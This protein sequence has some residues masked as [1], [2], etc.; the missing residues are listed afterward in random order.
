[1]LCSVGHFI[2]GITLVSSLYKQFQLLYRNPMSYSMKLLFSL[3]SHWQTCVLS[4]LYVPLLTTWHA[5]DRF[6]F[7]RRGSLC[8]LHQTICAVEPIV[9][10]WDLFQSASFRLCYR[11]PPCRRWTK[12]PSC[13]VQAWCWT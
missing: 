2:E 3:P 8:D 1:V 9:T 11:Q 6:L 5:T 7:L 4:P 13:A 10:W 12:L